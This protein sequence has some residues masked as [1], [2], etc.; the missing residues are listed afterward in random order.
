MK[1]GLI[2]KKVISLLLVAILVVFTLSG[3]GRADGNKDQPGTGAQDKQT[4]NNEQTQPNEQKSENNTSNEQDKSPEKVT[5]RIAG[6]K[7]P[8]SIG[9]VKLM[10]SAEKSEAANDYV[11]SIHGS[12]D[13]VT[14]KLIQG[15]L[16][17]AAIPANL[18]SVLYNNT[19]GAIQLL[20][21]NTLGVIYIVE[22]GNSVSSFN[23]LRG[24]TIYCTGKGSVP[25]YALRYLL[26]ENGIDPDKDVTLEWKSEPTEV[27]A[28]LSEAG[29]GVALLPQPY[30]TVAQTKIENLRI[31][32]DL[33]KAWTDLDNGSLMITGVLVVR[34]DFAEKYPQQVKAFLDEYQ[35]STKYVNAN[36]KEAAQ[37]VEK[38]NIVNAAVA[39][40]AIPYCNIVYMEGSEMQ[41]VMEGYLNVL[42]EQ[43]PKSVGGNLPQEDF[44][45]KK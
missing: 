3:C 24:K 38:F 4:E 42:F 31:A 20:A 12:A 21:V 34:K 9:M 23:D 1:E 27:V 6:L 44:Y 15:E 28:L 13:E 5:I 11:F 36:V 40:K 26:K 45:Y 35:E 18:A 14:P 7:G 41:T 33:N 25:E 17:M 32:I 8:T 29:S 16:D 30:V 37:L 2:M 39:E 22:N 43:N 10:E 19:Q